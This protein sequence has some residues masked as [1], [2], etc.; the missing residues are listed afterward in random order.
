MIRDI[1]KLKQIKNIQQADQEIKL[2]QLNTQQQALNKQIS[3][4]E[5]AYR[6]FIKS[7]TENINS[8]YLKLKL[9][10]FGT[11]QFHKFEHSL[12]VFENREKIF[13][14]EISTLYSDL[15][16][17]NK[18]VNSVKAVIKSLSTQQEKYN[19]ILDAIK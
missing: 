10:Q 13:K 1:N 2:L 5:E 11:E 14:E 9:C 12:K 3:N 18:E 8:F 19:F 4:T 7:K 16:E 6:L 17:V 15:Q